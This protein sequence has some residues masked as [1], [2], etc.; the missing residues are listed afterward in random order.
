M[1]HKWYHSVLE[2]DINP[3]NTNSLLAGLGKKEGKTRLM[4]M[5]MHWQVRIAMNTRRS[6]DID[7]A[8][9]FPLALKGHLSFLPFQ[10]SCLF[11]CLP[12]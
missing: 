2:K 9:D 10:W 4:N 5:A 3:V 1:Q 7:L 8:T 12:R 6:I 11:L